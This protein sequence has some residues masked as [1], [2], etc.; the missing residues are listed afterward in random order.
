MKS[1]NMLFRSFMIIVST[2]SISYSDSVT[3]EWVST[4]DFSGSPRELVVDSDGNVYVT[5]YCNHS[6]S[7]DYITLK[8]DN[9]GNQQWITSYNG[10]FAGW[11]EATAIG[12]GSD[13]NIIVTGFSESGLYEYRFVTIQ[14]NSDGDRQWYAATSS[15]TFGDAV[16]CTDNEGSIYVAGTMENIT[17]DFVTIKYN[18]EGD[19]QWVEYYDNGGSENAEAIVVDNNG[20]VI[21]AGNSSS[22]GYNTVKYDNNGAEVWTAITEEG[23]TVTGLALDNMGNIY[24]TGY[25]SGDYVTVKLDPDGTEQWVDQYDYDGGNDY[26]RAIAVDSAGNS[27]ITGSAM[28]EN[29]MGYD[30]RVYATVS[31]NTNGDFMWCREYTSW[32]DWSGAYDICLDG[33]SNAYVTGRDYYPYEAGWGIVTVKYSMAGAEEWIVS[34]DEGYQPTDVGIDEEGNV[35]V[36]GSSWNNSEWV[37]AKY[38]QELGIDPSQPIDYNQIQLLPIQPNPNSGTFNICFNTPVDAEVDIRVYDITGR[39]VSS[40]VG[41]GY[42][43]GSHEVLFNG[44]VSGVYLCQLDSGSMS[45]TRSFVVIR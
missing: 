29:Y 23:G 6:G 10:E 25:G 32:M 18:D 31:Y 35:Y 33:G 38:S 3:E 9:N 41:E 40:I 12:M 39:I 34:T 5:G 24:V 11:D 36:T 43:T 4:T 42:S 7:W 20:N 27:F 44:L 22:T 14:Y 16:L 13:G 1:L 8:Y 26:A 15:N 17:E 30:W 19:T 37:T 2:A 21:V 28:T 45:I